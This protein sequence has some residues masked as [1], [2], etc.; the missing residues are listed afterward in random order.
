MQNENG[1]AEEEQVIWFFG[2]ADVI[3]MISLSFPGSVKW[4]KSKAGR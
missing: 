1:Q 4:K 2:L 3:P